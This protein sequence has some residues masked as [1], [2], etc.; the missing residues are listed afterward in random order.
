MW[1]TSKTEGGGLLAI[2][3]KRKKIQVEIGKY[4][5]EKNKKRYM[6]YAKAAEFYS[7]PYYSLVRLAK[8]ADACWKIRRTVIVDLDKVDLYLEELRMGELEDGI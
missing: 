3:K 1:Q 5:T 8:Q 7:L 4:I 2:A 6:T